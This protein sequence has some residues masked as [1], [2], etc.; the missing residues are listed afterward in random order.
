MLARTHRENTS[1]SIGSACILVIA[2]YRI[3]IY[4]LVQFNLAK[5]PH[6]YVIPSVLNDCDRDHISILETET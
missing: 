2:L 1:T 4:H 6:A 5:L 3:A